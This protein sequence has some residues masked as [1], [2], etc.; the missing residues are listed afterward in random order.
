MGGASGRL[1]DALRPLTADTL[2]KEVERL[3]L[4]CQQQPRDW[5]GPLPVLSQLA[6]KIVTDVEQFL[7]QF[8]AA[9]GLRDE[10]GPVLQASQDQ[11]T[12]DGSGVSRSLPISNA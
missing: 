8:E 1:R 4:F 3:R 5:G 7:D 9:S 2:E 11:I 12:A 6:I 10:I